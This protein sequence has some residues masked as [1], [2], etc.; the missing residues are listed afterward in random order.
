MERLGGRDCGPR[1]FPGVSRPEFEKVPNDIE[2]VGDKLG[3]SPSGNDRHWIEGAGMRLEIFGRAQGVIFF[4]VAG[5]FGCERDGGRARDGEICAVREDGRIR[6]GGL[7]N[8]DDW[9]VMDGIED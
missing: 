7:V 5:V 9:V 1:R 6:E 8:I 4:V 3:P 2:R